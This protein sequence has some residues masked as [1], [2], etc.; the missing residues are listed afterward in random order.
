M[1]G[2]T[3][4]NGYPRWRDLDERDQRIREHHDESIR[5]LEDSFTRS[6][7]KAHQFHTDLAQKQN[8]SIG[9][10]LGRIDAVESVLDQQ[11][12]A[13]NLVYGLIGSNILLAV[14]SLATI[15]HLAGVLGG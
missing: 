12:G 14:L 1:A 9:E 5:R 4:T 10:L 11:R 2:E 13:R 3:A 6:L 8:L 7:D 15:L